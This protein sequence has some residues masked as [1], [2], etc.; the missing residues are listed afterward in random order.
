LHYITETT[1]CKANGRFSRENG[2]FSREKSRFSRE[3]SRFSREKS[4]FYVW[5]SLISLN[6]PPPKNKIKGFKKTTQGGLP[7]TC[8]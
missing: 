5:K 3:K 7:K 4:R 8:G 6:R 2:R 1:F